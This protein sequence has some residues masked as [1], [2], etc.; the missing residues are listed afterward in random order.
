MFGLKSRDVGR[1]LQDLELSYRPVELRT[2]HLPDLKTP[3]LFAH[4]TRDPFGTLE[5]L[6]AARRLIP[7]RTALIAL[8]GAAHDL[9][10]APRRTGS[11]VAAEIA[12]AFLQFVGAA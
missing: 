8:D 2:A 4:G 1:P 12:S 9:F 3:T 6:E 11:D 7:A 10:R 5:E